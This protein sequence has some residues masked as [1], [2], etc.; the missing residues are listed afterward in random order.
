MPLFAADASAQALNVMID[1]SVATGLE[2][3]GDVSQ[4]APT[5]LD[6][7]LGLVLDNDFTSEWGMGVTLQLEDAV[8]LGLTPQAR[9]VRNAAPWHFFL[10]AGV[11]V[12]V[13]PKT[14]YGL[15]VGAGVVH[16]LLEGVGVVGQV[17]LDWFFAGENLP[18][19]ASTVVR[20]NASLGVRVLF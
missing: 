5:A 14:L 8:A 19:A 12:F 11:P 9:L 15:E 18:K 2:R 3:V 20:L 4:R 17:G 13:M 1:A 6:V 16:D 7:D 10:G